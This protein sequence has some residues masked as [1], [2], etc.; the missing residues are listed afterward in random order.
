MYTLGIILLIVLGLYFLMDKKI[1]VSQEMIIDKPVEEVW[2]VMG[3]QFAQV[4]LWSSNFK[5]S[6]PGGMAKFPGLDHS[7]R[8][9]IT[10]RGETIQALDAFDSVAHSLSYHISKGA[11]SIAKDASAIWSLESTAPD[12]TKVLLEFN[13]ETKGLGFLMT[14]MIKKG[15]GQSAKEIAEDLKYYLENGQPH[16]RNSEGIE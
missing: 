4:H 11:P 14:P 10:E 3:N 5:D 6:K 13:M 12:Q 16:P 15:M 9:T 1:Q 2:K 8:I 7:E